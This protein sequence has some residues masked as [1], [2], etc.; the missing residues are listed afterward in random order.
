MFRKCSI[1]IVFWTIWIA[2]AASED[3]DIK[4]NWRTDRV[5]EAMQNEAVKVLKQAVSKFEKPYDIAK[6]A[7]LCFRTTYDEY[8]WHILITNGSSYYTCYNYNIELEV[9][10]DSGTETYVIF[11]ASEKGCN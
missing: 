1:F 2:N 7:S 9:T 11:A 8:F 6:Y 3:I 5:T 10:K 4:I